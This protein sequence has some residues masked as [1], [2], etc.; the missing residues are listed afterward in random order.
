MQHDDDVKFDEL[1]FADVLQKRLKVMD[2]AAISLAMD[3][4]KKILVFDLNI[5]GN[6]K[7]AICG[8]KVGTVIKGDE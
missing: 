2:A 3:N 6:I 7:N 5:P 8:A 1:Y 4:N